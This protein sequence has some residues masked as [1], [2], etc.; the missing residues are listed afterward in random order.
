M[1]AL[2]LAAKDLALEWR[3][4]E[5]LDAALLGALSLAVVAGVS[6]APLPESP[7]RL[8][9]V[10]WT[11]VL[12]AAL[13]PLARSFT[14][15]ADR[16]TLDVLLALPVDRGAI[17]LGKVLSNLV[18]TLGAVL[19]LLV[20]YVGVFGGAVQGVEGLVLTVLLGAL[21]L[22]A[23][24]STLAAIAAQA[25]AREALLPVLLFPLVLPVLL[26]AIP[27]TIHALRGDHL[28]DF[29][30]EL[31]LLLGYDV[32]FLAAGWLLFEFIVEG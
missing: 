8:A 23:T 20:A 9:A 32:A 22:S 15:E 1:N 19:V 30:G 10:L 7:E 5:L 18:V 6:L 26:S 14:G 31:Q 27:A 21:G 2:R 16:G 28:R 3:T 24:G 12:V 29:T 17:L 25:K 11:G 13:V 4:R